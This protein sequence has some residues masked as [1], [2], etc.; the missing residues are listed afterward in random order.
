LQVALQAGAVVAFEHAQFVDLALEQGPLAS[1]LAQSAVALLI[2]L[3]GHALPFGAGLGDEPVGFGLAVADV[4]VV[5]AL[6]QLQ[7]AGRRGGLIAAG[8]AGLLGTRRLFGGGGLLGLGGLLARVGG[9]LLDRKSVV[10][11]GH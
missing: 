4:L 8:G 6:G 5:Q 9:G 11:A 10:L 1:Q 7:H 3:A 2:G